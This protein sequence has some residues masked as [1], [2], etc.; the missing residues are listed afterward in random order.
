MWFTKKLLSVQWEF[1]IIADILLFSLETYILHKRHLIPKLYY[2]YID[3]ILLLLR[4]EISKVLVIINSFRPRLNFKEE[5][6]LINS[7][8]FLNITISISSNNIFTNWFNQPCYSG[9]YWNF[10]S[11]LPEIQKISG[12]STYLYN[13]LTIQKIYKDLIF[14]TFNNNGFSTYFIKNIINYWNI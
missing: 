9:R 12:S 5:I 14:H 6:L 1:L 8:N 11:Y 2:R 13:D 3:D 4:N 10:H 7:I